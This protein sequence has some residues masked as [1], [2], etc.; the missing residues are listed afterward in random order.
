MNRLVGVFLLLLVTSCATSHGKFGLLVADDLEASG[1]KGGK[2]LVDSSDPI[3]GLACFRVI[4]F[5]PL[6]PGSKSADEAIRKAVA[7]SQKHADTIVGIAD[8][9]LSSSY[10][11]VPPFYYDS[12]WR[13]KGKAAYWVSD[14]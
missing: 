3:E 1:K 5:V 4:V 10:A 6:F 8:A 11:S 7:S 14:K 9:E 13:V 2:I 12:C